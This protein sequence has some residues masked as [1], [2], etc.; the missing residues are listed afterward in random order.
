MPITRYNKKYL[1]KKL[2]F[3]IDDKTLFRTID[4][5]GLG[6]ERSTDEEIDIEFWNRPDL[7]STVGFSR[8]IRYFMRKSRN[9]EY[10][11]GSEGKEFTIKVGK[12]VEGIRPA[13]PDS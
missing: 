9:F 4:A 11:L 3:E 6:L 12:H 7:V 2:G 5:M 8:A 13:S 1:I 10:K